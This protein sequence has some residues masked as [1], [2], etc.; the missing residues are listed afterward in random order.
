MIVGCTGVADT[1]IEQLLVAVCAGFALSVASK[2]KF[3]VPAPVGVPEM[4]PPV[5]VRPAGSEPEE[6]DRVIGAV[7]P[8]VESVWLYAEPTTPV[9]SGQAEVIVNVAAGGAG[10]LTCKM[11]W[12]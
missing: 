8:L 4:T 7:P 9:G 1:A 2:V 5:N 6:R 10:G 3:A 11:H 12:T